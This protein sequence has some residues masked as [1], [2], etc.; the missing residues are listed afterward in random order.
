MTAI[1]SVCK[2]FATVESSYPIDNLKLLEWVTEAGALCQ[3]DRIYWCDGSEAER[4]RLTEEAV[5]ANVLIPLNQQKRPG[6]YLHRSHPTGQ[7]GRPPVGGLS[8]VLAG[9]RALEDMTVAVSASSA[10]GDET[11]LDVLFAGWV[12]PNPAEMLDSESMRALRAGTGREV[13]IFSKASSS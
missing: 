1:D 5:A 2:K 7:R 12:P 4:R 8:Q 3:P 13:S 10:E 6:C 11:E 9:G